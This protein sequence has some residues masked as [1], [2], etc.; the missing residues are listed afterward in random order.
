MELPRT[1]SRRPPPPAGFPPLPRWLVPPA[2]LLAIW[3]L[4]GLQSDAAAA[5]ESRFLAVLVAAVLAALAALST[6]E[7][8]WTALLAT[9]AAWIAYHGPSRGAVVTLILAA[10]L[11]V[12]AE[13]AWRRRSRRLDP[14]LTVPAAIAL[15]L[16]LR[17]DLLLPPLLDAR[18]LV[19]V[20]ALPAAAGWAVSRL[21]ARFGA[22]R[23]LVAGATAV[24]LAPGWNV[25]STLGLVALGLGTVLAEVER[26][27]WLRWP[28][29]GALLLPLAWKPS[30]GAVTALAGL[31]LWL[32]GGRRTGDR[33]TGGHRRPA[34]VAVLLAAG[35][36]L[37]FALSPLGGRG[38]LTLWASG[39][40]VLPALALAPAEGRWRAVHGLLLAFLAAQLGHRPE[41]LAAGL[42]L[43]ALG[44]PIRGAA[45]RLQ[46]A[47]TGSLVAGTTLLA[48][49]PWMRATPRLDLMA[50]LGL[51][52]PLFAL[53]LLAGSAAVLA[54]LLDV[55]ARGP[56][57][58][59]PP[60]AP[61]LLVALLL[62]LALVPTAGPSTVLVDSYGPAALDGERR[63]WR[64]E[65]AD[66]QPALRV[67]TLVLDS[68]LVHGVALA[69]GT[70]VAD[71]RLLDALGGELATWELRAGSDTAEWAAA[72]PDVAG[73]SGFVAP[74]AWIS[75]L[76]PDG[77]FFARRFRSRLSVSPA[78]G[79]PAAGSPDRRAAAV[80]ID[81]APGLPPEVRLVIY[82]LELRP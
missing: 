37:L 75:R 16:L 67:S 78:V 53:A 45:N 49:Y 14:G 9:A 28:A 65:L 60:A 36:A 11:A 55:A 1:S 3:G 10:G 73:L 20:L 8:G 5:A 22:A 30:L 38:S 12:A 47:W 7:L 79:S 26:P 43:A 70:P 58:R 48:A 80:T 68:H 33:R 59:L 15:Q 29:A 34:A 51:G 56:G 32:G 74:P 82:R 66:R 24:V 69:A 61:Q 19:S 63:Q 39:L 44:T 72:R 18:T 35:A 31:A 81:R 17:S 40:T 6:R 42:A 27:R 62:V 52:D 2:A 23:A 4:A 64:A 76:A 71:V 50:L 57:L 21:A 25:T 54:P 13:G 46:V 41:A 77:S